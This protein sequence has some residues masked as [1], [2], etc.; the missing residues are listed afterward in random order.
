MEFSPSAPPSLH[1][2]LILDNN[3]AAFTKKK[4][5][6]PPKCKSIYTLALHLFQMTSLRNVVQMFKLWI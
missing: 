6:K 3:S 2:R 4:M 1:T 5:E